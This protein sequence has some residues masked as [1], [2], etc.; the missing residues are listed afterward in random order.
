MGDWFGLLRDLL[1]LSAGAILTLFGSYLTER[2]REKREERQRRRERLQE[3]LEPLNKWVENAMAATDI[4]YEL[5]VREIKALPRIIPPLPDALQI[6]RK[7]AQKLFLPALSATVLDERGDLRSKLQ[8]FVLSEDELAVEMQKRIPHS[9]DMLERRMALVA[10]ARELRR[11][12]D[13]ILEGE[14]PSPSW[15]VRIK[16]RLRRR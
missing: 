1:L 11:R 2:W 15:W 14:A 8:Q 16:R 6:A 12:V 9:M 5:Q 3:R 7:R 13:E 10:A 4:W